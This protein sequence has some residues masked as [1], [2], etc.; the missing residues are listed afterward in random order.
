MNTSDYLELYRSEASDSLLALENGL[1]GLE[2]SA[3]PLAHLN[4]LFRRAHNLKGISGAM[5]YDEVVEASHDLENVFDELRKGAEI[6]P[7]TMD[8]LLAS[9]DRLKTLVRRAAGEAADAQCP[10]RAASPAAAEEAPAERPSGVLGERI[11]ATKVGL[12]RLDRIM[13]LVGELVVSRIRCS[14]IAED[15]GSRP[16]LDELARSWRLVSQIQKEVMEA[17]LIPVGHVFQRFHRLVRELSRDTGKP[18]KLDI[19]GAEIGLDRVVLEGMVDPL[20]HLIRNAVGHGIESPEERRAAGKPEMGRIILSA[21]RERNRVVI[22]VVDDGRGVDLDRIASA[23]ASRAGDLTEDD[24]CR[25]ITAPGFSTARGVDTISGRGMGM[26]IVKKTVD[27]FGGSIRVRTTQG[28][29]TMISLL[30]PI[31]L[32]IIKALLFTIGSDVHAIPVEYVKETNRCEVGSLKTVGGE[33][34]LPGD[35]EVIPVLRPSQLFERT[36]EM[37]E[38]RFAKFIVIDTGYRRAAVVVSRVLGQQ[39]IVIKSLPPLFRGVRGISG[40]TVLGSGKIAFIWDPQALFEGRCTYE[41][42]Q[43]AFVSPS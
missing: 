15:L 7:E 14:A 13:D 27:S 28:R 4:E 34:V 37:P 26:N 6:T 17:R 12:E 23:A 32:S 24:I 40:A 20:V 18:L 3:E 29:G 19:N 21:S 2:T 10:A 36:L 35:G 42:D 11:T 22:E 30:I 43:A 5:G 41:P 33:L 1:I 31:N 25:V 9:V 39:D 16:I 38:E 8:G